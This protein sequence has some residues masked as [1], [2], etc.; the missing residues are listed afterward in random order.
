MLGI[1]ESLEPVLIEEYSE[2]FEIIVAEV[3]VAGKDIRIINAYGPEENWTSEEKM[4]FFLALEEEISKAKLHGKLV[5]LELDANSKLGPQYIKDDPHG[6]SQNGM[7]LSGIIKRHELV[8]AFCLGAQATAN[9][10]P[11]SPSQLHHWA[12][13]KTMEAR[14]TAEPLEKMQPKLAPADVQ[15]QTTLAL[16]KVWPQP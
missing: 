14:S 2:N 16:A 15:K 11:H 5:I 4:P 10:Q 8:V 12:R 6:M 1:H 3:K 7:I 9:R 13:P